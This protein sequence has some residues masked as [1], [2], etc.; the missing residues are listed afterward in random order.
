[1]KTKPVRSTRLRCPC[2]RLIARGKEKKF[3]GICTY[4]ARN[5][6]ASRQDVAFE[7]H[8]TAPMIAEQGQD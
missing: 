2:G 3:N 1:M 6:F 8:C 5:G 4:C 7:F